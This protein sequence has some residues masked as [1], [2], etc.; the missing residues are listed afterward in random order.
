MIYDVSMNELQDIQELHDAIKRHPFRINKDLQYQKEYGQLFWDCFLKCYEYTKAHELDDDK[1]KVTKDCFYKAY[2]DCNSVYTQTKFYK[3][4]VIA[5]DS[6]MLLEHTIG[7][8]H[9]FIDYGWVDYYWT[10]YTGCN[11][12]RGLPRLTKWVYEDKW[13]SNYT[14]HEIEEALVDFKEKVSKW[15]YT[16]MWDKAS[17]D[18]YNEEYKRAIVLE[19]VRSLEKNLD[20]STE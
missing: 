10:Y 20:F 19:K 5:G 7:M 11:I 14:S 17:E 1:S 3:D 6:M 15:G 2:H 13:H 4:C 8:I 16:V 12:L 18:W 9:R